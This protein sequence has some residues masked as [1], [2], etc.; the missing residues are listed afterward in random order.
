MWIFI[1]FFK[2]VITHVACHLGVD[3]I[4]I[5]QKITFAK[6]LKLKGAKFSFFL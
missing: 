6:G 1:L 5:G 2:L 4:K 3:P